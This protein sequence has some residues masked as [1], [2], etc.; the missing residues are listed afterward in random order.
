MLTPKKM[1]RL[2]IVASKDQLA[3]ITRALYRSRLFHIE[4]YVVDG[5]EGYDGFVIGKPLE[6]A[7][8]AS[9]NLIKVRSI[10]NIFAISADAIEPAGRQR[11]ADL[12]SVIE[13]ELASIGNEVEGLTAR[14]S[15]LEASIKEN[16]QRISEITPFVEIPIDL[17]LYSGY[18]RFTVIAGHVTK[19]VTIMEPAEFRIVK[20]KTS[21]FVVAVVPNANR[22]EVERQLAEAGFAAVQIPAE[23]GM[24]QARIDDYKAKIAHAQA[25]IE[26]INLNLDAIRQKHTNFLVACEEVLKSDV[27]QA[28][29]P[30]RFATTDQTFVAEGWVPADS[31]GGITESIMKA[32]GNKAFVT[33][34][35][36][37]AHDIV[38]VEY[39]NPSFA[40]PSQFFMDIYSRP[41]Y[42]EIDPTLM[43]SIIFPIFFG[44][45]LGDIGYGLILLVLCLALRK[46]IKGEEGEYFLT[47]IRNASIS[48]I[49][50]GVLNSE[51]LGFPMPWWPPF[52]FSR[53]LAAE[54]GGHGPLIPEL[55]IM[56]VWIGILHITLG[57][58]LGMVNHARQ[59]HGDHRIKA[60][61][62]N[63]GWLSVMWGVLLL[64]WSAIA[65]PLM[66]DLTWTP[67][68]VSIGGL[69]MGVPGINLTMI[70]GG[71]MILAGILFIA[72]DSVLEVI[73]LPTIISHVLSYA[74]IVA[75]GLSSVAIAMVVN[76]IAIGMLIEPQ[77][78]N[79]TIFGVVIIIAGIVVFLLGHALNTALGILGGGLHSIRL[80]YVEFFTKF[81]KGGGLKY[82]PFGLKRRFT[83]D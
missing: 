41:K 52:A 66:P 21:H 9:E 59:D 26:S 30:L 27:E 34:L 14:R 6:G 67:L 32:T 62:A 50:F 31:V 48:S 3:P 56:S 4:D 25:E 20:G 60:V 28:E 63:A 23:T 2:L 42:T 58:V 64:I 75:V 8:E 36:I 49:F 18:E 10:A 12:K 72:R 24:P 70:I 47:I 53:H 77:L 76:Y 71:I 37:G 40:K 33:E 11:Q 55:L 35:P 78:T 57:R 68:V 80:H 7:S 44:L 13:R 81:Y 45:I 51:F 65:M 38:P 19:N 43:L 16:E 74:R 39:N 17:S 29:A 83:E 69:P 22:S 1:S 61:L 15:L 82:N 5:R 73:E 79:L 46:Y 54:G